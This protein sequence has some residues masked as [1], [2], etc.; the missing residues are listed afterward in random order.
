M[1]FKSY[2]N[3]IRS[4]RVCVVRCNMCVHA[5]QRIWSCDTPK[6]MSVP[7]LRSW[8]LNTILYWKE[9]G[10]WEKCLSPGLEVREVH[11]DLEHVLVPERQIALKELWRYVKKR[12]LDWRVPSWPKVDIFELQNECQNRFITLWIKQEFMSSL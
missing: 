9:P 6:T 7:G 8:F 1:V 2:R 10:S 12:K 3:K 4:L 5:S 11:D